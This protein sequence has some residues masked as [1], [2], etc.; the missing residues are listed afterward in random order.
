MDYDEGR[1]LIEELNVLITPKDQVYTHVW[2][3]EPVHRVGQSL[4]PA[5]RHRFRR[6]E[7]CAR[8][9]AVYD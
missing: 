5:P 4:H 3:R 8:D 1:A 2:S 6:G 7:P 9:A